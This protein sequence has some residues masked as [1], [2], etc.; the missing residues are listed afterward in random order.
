MSERPFVSVIVPIRNEKAHLEI[1]LRNLMEQ[2]YPTD[3]FEI[4]IVD[5]MSTDGTRE[6][7][8]HFSKTDSRIRLIDNPK[9]FV[10][11]AFNMGIRAARG[12]IVM[13]VGGHTHVA[14]NY[15][16]ESVRV[17]NDHPEVVGTGGPVHSVA[18]TTFGRAVAVAMAHP[19][20]IGNATHRYP[21][22]EGYAFG[23]AFPVFRKSLFDE[24]GYYDE[25]F[26]RNQDDEFLLRLQMMGLKNYITP[27][28]R[29]D[30]FVRETPTQ[31]FRQFVQYGYWRVAVIQKLKRAASLRQF[32]PSIFVASLIL[33][34]VLN[35]QAFL[36]LFGSYGL[37]LS[38]AA[39]YHWRQSSFLTC[40]YLPIAISLMH[41]GYAF[42]FFRGLLDFVLLRRRSS[43]MVEMTRG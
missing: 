17:L 34:F 13:I 3:R 26:V 42:G 16:T 23:S 32:A 2:D 24:V 39:L 15:I 18:R 20:G 38:L 14:Q 35:I 6:L 27:K 30:Y 41:F 1:T 36:M 22:F 7:C 25:S 31:L 5:G 12:D 33:A 37:T 40:C 21:N 28:I 9:L 11:A 43:S 10:A 4:L 29:S 8:A 19:L